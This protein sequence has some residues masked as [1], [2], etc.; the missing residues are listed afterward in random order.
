LLAN[1]FGQLSDPGIPGSKACDL[2]SCVSDLKHCYARVKHD[3]AMK[4][5]E[6]I[7]LAEDRIRRLYEEL[8]FAIL[9]TDR[10][11]LQQWGGRSGGRLL[12]SG[13]RRVGGLTR[14]ATLVGKGAWQEMTGLVKA[15]GQGNLGVHV[16]DRTAAAIDGSLAFGRESARVISVVSQGLIANPK[17]AAPKILGA[18]L[19]F[20]AGSGGVD[21]N[22][23]IPDLDLLV[24]IGAHRSI[25]THSILAGML[26]EGALLSIADL[27]TLIHERLPI[28][29]DPLWDEL[30]K[31]ASPL[32]QSLATGTSAGI[33]YHL[34]VDAFIQ[35]AP[36]HDLPFGMPI[37][38]HQAVMGANGAAE[39]AN[40][41][42]RSMLHQSVEIVQDGLPEKSTGRKVVDGVATAASVAQSA[43]INTL[44]R[45]KAGWRNRKEQT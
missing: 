15:A 5:A 16:G 34:L 10:V 26:A 29:H 24:G 18:F 32:T 19:G 12:A 27:A 33:A 14:F 30:A 4:Y 25:V 23:G 45:V 42:K 38:G 17:E 2:Q 13:A 3:L 39:G 9:R 7:P 11:A 40:A 22:G 1:E 31:S 6:A 37:E 43:A 36:Y 35:P 28:D 21:G 44:S 41:A 20:Y 8:S